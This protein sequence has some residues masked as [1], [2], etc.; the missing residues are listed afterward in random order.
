MSVLGPAQETAD[1][2]I[3]T[4]R[5]PMIA[6]RRRGRRGPVNYWSVADNLAQTMKCLQRTK[7]APYDVLRTVHVLI[8]RKSNC[9]K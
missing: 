4:C 2:K 1:Q 6:P 9:F 8:G 3:G 7:Y 5:N